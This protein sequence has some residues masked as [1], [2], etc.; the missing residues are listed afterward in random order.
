MHPAFSLAHLLSDLCRKMLSEASVTIAI[1]LQDGI[2]LP[3][4]LVLRV[5]STNQEVKCRCTASSWLQYR[6]SFGRRRVEIVAITLGSSVAPSLAKE[7]ELVTTS[8]LEELGR[9]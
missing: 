4:C 2:C 8:H 1:H 5:G 6:P 9:W 3:A 7:P